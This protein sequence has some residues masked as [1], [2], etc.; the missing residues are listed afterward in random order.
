MDNLVQGSMTYLSETMSQELLDFLKRGENN[1][2]LSHIILPFCSDTTGERNPVAFLTGNINLKSNLRKDGKPVSFEEELKKLEAE[3]ENLKV[4]KGLVVDLSAEM[5]KLQIET[6]EK[7]VEIKEEWTL[8]DE[9]LFKTRKERK[10][11]AYPVQS[12]KQESKLLS[13]DI[14]DLLRLAEMEEEE[15]EAE[16]IFTSPSKVKEIKMEIIN[17]SSKGSSGTLKELPKL[18]LPKINAT[19]ALVGEIIER[20]SETVKKPFKRA[21]V[22]DEVSNRIILNDLKKIDLKA[23]A[24]S[25]EEAD[26]PIQSSQLKKPSLFSLRKQ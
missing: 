21:T 19:N 2:T 15:E 22:P 9:I 26:A 25:Q 11:T 5:K 18:K 16:K 3:I 20:E 24:T 10:M 23:S 14:E 12:V 4:N 8:E 7:E 17:Q 1:S 13:S 6:D